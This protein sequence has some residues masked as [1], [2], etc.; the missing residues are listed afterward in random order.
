MRPFKVMVVRPIKTPPDVADQSGHSVSTLTTYYCLS[1]AKQEA[2][3]LWA[4]KVKADGL[5]ELQG[6]DGVRCG[7]SLQAAH[8]F[9]R[10]YLGT[11]YVLLNGWALCAGHHRY[12]TSAPLQWDALMQLRLGPTVY[13]ELRQKALAFTGPVDYSSVLKELT[14]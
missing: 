4:A 5:C 2:D 6:V 12:Y 8:G 10:R 1:H 13:E 9:S 3:R 7:G 14:A 11:R